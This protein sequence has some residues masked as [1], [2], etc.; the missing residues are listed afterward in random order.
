MC[1]CLAWSPTVCLKD[2]PEFP[3]S[4]HQSAG[5]TSLLHQSRFYLVLGT[6]PRALSLL[7]KQTIA[8]F[9]HL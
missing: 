8:T 3:I 9:P 1:P 6:E 4:S 5:I 7:G 2:D